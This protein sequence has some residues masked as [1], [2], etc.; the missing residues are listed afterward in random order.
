MPETYSETL[1]EPEANGTVRREYVFY[2]EAGN[3]VDEAEAT[4]FIF[5][6]FDADGQRTEG[7]RGL[8]PLGERAAARR[9]HR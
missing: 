7:G 4:R 1:E 6:G 8:T 9:P 3:V 2:D 5:E